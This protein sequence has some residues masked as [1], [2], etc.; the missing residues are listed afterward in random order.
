M[1]TLDKE[2]LLQ[3]AVVL[4]SCYLADLVVQ[5]VLLL[6][7]SRTPFGKPIQDSVKRQWPLHLMNSTH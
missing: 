6:R 5:E 3:H 2:A 4:Y 7:C 1:N